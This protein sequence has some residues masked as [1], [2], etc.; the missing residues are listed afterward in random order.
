MNLHEIT[1][2][3]PEEIVN[4]ARWFRAGG[5]HNYTI[6]HNP[7]TDETWY[8]GPHDRINTPL[9]PVTVAAWAAE[10]EAAFF[11]SEPVA[12]ELI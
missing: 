10:G 11:K 4:L 6:I 9:A 1:P 3:I 7:I 12:I 5:H 8:R 2:A